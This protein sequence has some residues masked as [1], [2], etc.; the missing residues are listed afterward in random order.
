MAWTDKH[1]HTHT[2]RR[3]ENS[4]HF[5]LGSWTKIQRRVRDLQASIGTKKVPDSDNGPRR[6]SEETVTFKYQSGRKKVPV[7]DNGHHGKSTLSDRKPGPRRSRFMTRI[8][9]R[10]R[11]DTATFQ[12]QPGPR[13]SP[14]CDDGPVESHGSL[15]FYMRHSAPSGGCAAK[16]YRYVGII[17]LC[18]E[19]CWTR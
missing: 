15:E 18:T 13:W 17:I 6:K 9:A 5:E 2:D 10:C 4:G 3:T 16:F 7:C 8:P 12:H 1:T 11:R 14:V 19:T